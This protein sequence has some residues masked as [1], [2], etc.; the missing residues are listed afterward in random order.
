MALYEEWWLWVVVIGIIIVVVD[1]ILLAIFRNPSWWFWFVLILGIVIFVMGLV[2]WAVS[3]HAR[4]EKPVLTQQQLQQ[5]QAILAAESRRQQRLPITT[6]FTQ[7]SPGPEGVQHVTTRDGLT[8]THVPPQHAATIQTPSG[9]T[10]HATARGATVV[11]P[12]AET[13][14]T[15]RT[16]R[17]PSPQPVRAPV[18]RPAPVRRPSPV[19]RPR[20]TVTT[21]RRRTQ[22]PVVRT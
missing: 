19:P 4:E 10:I 5:R 14:T 20:A 8:H 2:W 11:P 7:M 3:R 13:V 17:R 9:H 6:Q 12:R 15:T 1:L 16:V 18:S 21:T 22:L